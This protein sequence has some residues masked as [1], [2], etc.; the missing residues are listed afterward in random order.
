MLTDVIDTYRHLT[1][2]IEKKR[3]FYEQGAAVCVGASQIE[4]MFWKQYPRGGV[5][6]RARVF[7][8]HASLYVKTLITYILNYF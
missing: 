2:S 8:I 6:I 3:E 1:G 4:V 7:Q 5:N